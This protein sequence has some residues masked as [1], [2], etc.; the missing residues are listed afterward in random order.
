VGCDVAEEER[1]PDSGLKSSFEE[2]AVSREADTRKIQ[3]NWIGQWKDED[4]REVLVRE[5]A[6]DFEF[7]HPDVSV[8]LVFS[9]DLAGSE[10]NHKKRAADAIV[11]MTTTGK[12]EWDVVFLD[13]AVYEH[14]SEKLG[15][16]R[17]TT[18]HL[19]DFSTVPGF[20]DSQ[21]DF[22]VEDPS[23]KEKLGGMFTG[24]FIENYIMNV[25][26]NT[27]VADRIGMK[28][29]ERGMTFDDFL[30][31]AEKV[32]RYNKEN[33]TSIPFIKL[34]A[35][36]RVDFLFESLFKSL[37]DDFESAVEKTFNEKKRQAFLETLLAFEELSNFQPLFN[38]NPG[39]ISFEEFVKQ[40]LY[41]DD[42]LFILGGTFLYSH[43]NALD[44]EKS[45]KMRLAENPY[46][47][48]YNGL[49]G[50]YTPVFA[51][52]KKSGNRDL[53]VELLMSWAKPSNAEKWVK[54]AK[55][56]TGSKRHLPGIVTKKIDYFDDVHELYITDM[57]EKYRG[58]PMVYMR[59][60]TYI[61]GDR[62]PVDITEFRSKL[63]QILAGDLKAR[64]YFEDVM[65][66][67]G[68]K[69]R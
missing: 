40:I 43:F 29:K 55:N 44:K 49:V 26:Y 21:E 34:P 16:P 61:F 3:L 58:V 10:P 52:M 65:A 56:L 62:N 51:V 7:L 53:A 20:L 19:V 45:K 48:N 1:T 69:A 25:W 13:V 47:R 6:R 57:E 17:W 5:I 4:M 46:L 15:N 14:V 33:A 36:N 23:Y 24:P 39:T 22:I 54:Y 50:D 8:N 59:E 41:D 9:K 32:H 66:R 67:M 2:S 60:P 64:E 68:E 27:S 11:K 63:T 42:A 38:E 37:F 30:G 31:Y 35:W 18:E 28:I 12:I